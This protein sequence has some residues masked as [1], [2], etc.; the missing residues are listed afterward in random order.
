MGLS[1]L[2][3][4]EPEKLGTISGTVFDKTS[5]AHPYVTI[6]IKDANGTVV[7]GGVTDE[8]GKFVIEEI[9]EENKPFPSSTLDTKLTLPKWKLPDKTVTRIWG[10]FT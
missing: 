1:S 9:P 8:N 6:V 5:T 3:N 2:A 4:P 7:T 10:P